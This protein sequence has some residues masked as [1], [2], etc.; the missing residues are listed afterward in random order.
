MGYVIGTGDAL[1]YPR[2]FIVGGT[3]A[4]MRGPVAPMTTD[5]K[6]AG[7]SRAAQRQ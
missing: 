6:Y 5:Q 7:F 3:V 1:S 2:R 4:S